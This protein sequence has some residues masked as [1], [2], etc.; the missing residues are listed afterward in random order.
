MLAQRPIATDPD[1]PGSRR[2]AID[3]KANPLMRAL[4][5]RTVEKEEGFEE[6]IRL[7]RGPIIAHLCFQFDLSHDDPDDLFQEFAIK[8]LDTYEE[9]DAF[10]AW[11]CRIARNLTIDR[12]RAWKRRCEFFL[13]AAAFDALH[14][15]EEEPDEKNDY[16]E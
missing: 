13:D 5:A 8:L 15:L 10:M 7:I 4:Q 12:Y 9:Y 2:K 3:E 1:N 11:A 16:G 14:A 6:L